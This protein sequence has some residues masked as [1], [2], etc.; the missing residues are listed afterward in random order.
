MDDERA[1]RLEEILPGIM[2]VLFRTDP[3]D[4]LSEL[5]L[6]QLRMMRLLTRGER[7]PSAIG[8]EL[9][10][11]ASAITQMA[12][13]LESIGFLERVQD[14][15]DRRVRRLRLTPEAT[16]LMEIRRRN[17]AARAASALSAI[18]EAQQD[19]I[20]KSL[21][22]LYSACQATQ[23]TKSPESLFVVSQIEKPS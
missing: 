6:A 23:E 1:N 8:S 14:A 18:P 3:K 9:G 22:Q 19:A 7:L 4:P 21:E 5:P 10:L 17:R 12:N 20:L 16:R 15:E 11:S 2:R 13:R